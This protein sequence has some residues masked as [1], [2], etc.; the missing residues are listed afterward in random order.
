MNLTIKKEWYEIAET[1]SGSIQRAAFYEM[2]TRYFFADEVPSAQDHAG[3]A[4]ESGY[5]MFMLIRPEID[6]EKHEKELRRTKKE[7][8]PRPAADHKPTAKR[9][10]T[11]QTATA[12]KP[13]AARFVKPTAEEIAAYCKEKGYS[14]NAEQFISYYESNGWRIGRNPMENWRA[15]VTNWA[16]R[17]FDAPR[18][19]QAGAM[20]GNENELPDDYL[21]LI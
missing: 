13:K 18:T 17:K 1:M 3:K 7:T 20:W 2:I 16:K 12:E 8:K 4:T 6:R 11:D 19:K 21:N 10:P 5:I 9:P 15:A 14:V